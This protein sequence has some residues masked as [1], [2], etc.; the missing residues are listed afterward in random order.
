MNINNIIYQHCS[1]PKN[2]GD[3]YKI[4]D[5]TIYI[6]PSLME[7][8][9]WKRYKTFSMATYVGA[10][11]FLL[12]MAFITNLA[13]TYYHTHQ[14]EY[15]FSPYYIETLY[16]SFPNVRAMVETVSQTRKTYNIIR[17]S[18]IIRDYL[19]LDS[20]GCFRWNA[21]EERNERIYSKCT[22]NNNLKD[23][24]YTFSDRNLKL[25]KVDISYIVEKC[26]EIAEK[27]V[28]GTLERMKEWQYECDGMFF[29]DNYKVRSYSYHHK[30]P[31]VKHE[32]IDIILDK[33]CGMVEVPFSEY[34]GYQNNETEL[35]YPVSL[36]SS[37]HVNRDKILSILQ[38]INAGEKY[39]IVVLKEL[40][41]MY[42]KT[43]NENTRYDVYYRQTKQGRHYTQGSCVQMFSKEL[44]KEIFED[45]VELDIKSSVFTLYLNLARKYG[46]KKPLPQLKKM[47]E[48]PKAYRM[49]FVN[50][51][52]SYEEVKTILTAIAYGARSDIYNMYMEMTGNFCFHKSSLLQ[53]GCNSRAVFDMVCTDEIIELSEEIHAL[54]LYLMKKS[55]VEKNIIENIFGY[56]LSTGRGIS[57]G[58]KLAHIYQA[59]EAK[60]LET[61]KNMSIGRKK[62]CE[63][64]CGVA[65]YLHD[66]I[67]IHRDIAD[68]IGDIAECASK[69]VMEK[70]GF[71]IKYDVSYCS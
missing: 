64:D 52:M 16:R 25:Y 31:Y 71:E 11:E 9:S 1:C 49:Q 37:F 5:T 6:L 67:Y 59:W 41:R 46:Y 45:Y 26:K 32:Y 43:T 27:G 33:K 15:E 57:F 56:R 36:K 7:H 3:G 50:D 2:F 62:L 38:D 21:I 53:M 13:Y 40:S 28:K 10:R 47:V 18:N 12:E 69:V 23:L 20:V 48:N 8:P 63:I 65:L 24:S 22:I 35:Q 29:S 34:D 70:T 68:K 61:V 66:G 58:K 19:T 17:T 44:R 55:K 30:I 51:K 60:I 42:H 14:T 4:A 39:N 54:G